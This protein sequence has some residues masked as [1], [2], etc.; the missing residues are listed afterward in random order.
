MRRQKTQDQFAFAKNNRWAYGV[1]IEYEVH[2]IMESL[3][4][5]RSQSQP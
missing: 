3:E 1:M 2:I 4:E 5:Q